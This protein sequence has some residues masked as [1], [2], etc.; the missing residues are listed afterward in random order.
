M[1]EALFKRA[2]YLLFFAVFS[3]FCLIRKPVY[4]TPKPQLQATVVCVQ[5]GDVGKSRRLLK[6]YKNQISL[7]KEQFEMCIGLVL[8]DAH[9]QTQDEGKTHRLKFEVGDKNLDYLNHIQE[10][11]DPFILSNPNEIVRVNKYG[12]TVKTFQLQTISHADFN[13]LAN[14]FQIQKGKKSINSDFLYRELT[15]RGVAY[16]FMDDGGKLDYTANEGKGIVF[17]TQGFEREEVQTLCDILKKKFGYETW[18]KKNKD[19]FIVAVSGKSYEDLTKS[20][21]PHII[22]SMQHK[23]PKPRKS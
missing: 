12:K 22:P 3:F 11:L 6:Q 19:K 13:A 10:V 4:A 15:P 7:K 20:V 1:F 5:K 2:T 9:L 16:W 14:G 17:N 8:G 18:Q 21:Y 23:W